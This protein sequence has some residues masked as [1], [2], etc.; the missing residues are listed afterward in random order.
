[1]KPLYKYIISVVVVVLFI[2][3]LRQVYLSTQSEDGKHGFEDVYKYID[4]ENDDY[5]FYAFNYFISSDDS[6]IEFLLNKINIEHDPDIQITI[7][8]ILAGKKCLKCTE[9]FLEKTKDPSWK[10]R[11]FAIDSLEYINYLD[12]KSIIRDIL[13]NDESQRVK[14]KAIMFLSYNKDENNMKFLTD[15]Y[16]NEKEIKDERVLKMLRHVLEIKDLHPS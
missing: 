5:K 4:S 9:L 6:V 14:F 10:V 7:M 1:M 16:N 8:Q 11:F 15:Y 13:I 12:E 2:C 3:T